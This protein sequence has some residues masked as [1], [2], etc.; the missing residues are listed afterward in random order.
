MEQKAL[1]D[2]SKKGPKCAL[3]DFL[4][5]L[6]KATIDRGRVAIGRDINKA[7]VRLILDILRLPLGVYKSNGISLHL[8]SDVDPAF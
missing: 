2:S 3:N 8:P 1:F 5:N 6:V 7:M 4:A